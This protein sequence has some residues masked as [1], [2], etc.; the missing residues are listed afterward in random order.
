MHVLPTTKPGRIF[1]WVGIAGYV[2]I[3]VHY[4]LAMAFGFSFI[5]PGII[6]LLCVV[7][8]GI[9]SVVA[10]TKYHER[11][12]LSFIAALFGC[13]GL[14]LVAGEFLFPH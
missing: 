7:G 1:S 14:L 12:I 9:G 13:L 5:L 6:A 4:W 11:S 3:N 2:L 10:I 8:G